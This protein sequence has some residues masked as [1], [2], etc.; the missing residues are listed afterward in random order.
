MAITPPRPEFIV[1]CNTK[2]TP[3][4][5]NFPVVATPNT[6]NKGHCQNAWNHETNEPPSLI[7]AYRHPADRPTWLQ[8]QGPPF[9]SEGGAQDFS[10]RSGLAHRTVRQRTYVRRS[11][12]HGVRRGWSHLRGPEL[13]LSARHRGRRR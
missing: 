9:P 12:R 2:V 13:R 7:S 10:N 3:C 1:S 5:L 4:S 11:G 6:S 8:P